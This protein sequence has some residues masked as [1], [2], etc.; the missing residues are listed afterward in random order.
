MRTTR[1]RVRRER[2]SA[3]AWAIALVVTM[4]VV[5][6]LTL[7]A[8]RPQPVERVS[9]AQ[10]VTRAVAL[11]AVEGWCVS[12]CA[13]DPAEEARVQASAFTSRGAAGVVSRESGAWHVLGAAY[14]TRREAERIAGRLERDDG[15]SAAV[16]CVS[17]EAVNLRV[18][19]PERQI[20][21]VSDADALLRA[22]TWQLGD[23]AL[24]LDRNEIRPDAARTLCALAAT[25]A[26]QASKALSAVPGAA[27]NALCAGLIARLDAL[28]TML[29]AV[30]V[31]RSAAG[32]PLSG[33]LRCAQVENLLGLREL[34]AGLKRE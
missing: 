14:A 6:F 4:L 27:D 19:A 16:L 21:A 17:A 28:R 23:I 29:D 1:V 32:A 25:E 5:Y 9:A 3:M 18:T 34:Q 31:D 22:Q 2:P 33:M 15:I 24:Q 13:C 20:D 26:R 11:E 10:R 12:L 7:D 8:A 30:A